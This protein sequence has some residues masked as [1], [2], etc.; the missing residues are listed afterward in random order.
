M[1]A[2]LFADRESARGEVGGREQTS[3]LSG[4]VIWQAGKSE[5]GS[6]SLLGQAHSF[7]PYRRVWLG[8]AGRAQKKL[9]FPVENAT[10]LKPR[11]KPCC[12]CSFLRPNVCR[13]M[14][15]LLQVNSTRPACEAKV[16]VERYPIGAGTRGPCLAAQPLGAHTTLKDS[17]MLH[18]W[19]AS[20]SP[21]HGLTRKVARLLPG[22]SSGWAA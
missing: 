16:R 5:S 20:S 2:T 12:H 18:S 4:D 17:A 14:V 21:A 8:F 6:L 3:P 19:R 1:P 11:K 22:P 10:P 13:L 9:V 7:R 15:P